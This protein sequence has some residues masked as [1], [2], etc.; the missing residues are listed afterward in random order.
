MTPMSADEMRAATCDSQRPTLTR[1]G[2]GYLL[3][4]LA[5]ECTG[6]IAHVSV[7]DP[8]NHVIA[9]TET[10]I[11]NDGYDQPRVDLP[12]WMLNLTYSG[13]QVALT[14]ETKRDN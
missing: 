1:S 7:L 12:D 11:E 6:R 3:I 5:P 9:D 10:P 13:V 2:R 8:S 4:G 14:V